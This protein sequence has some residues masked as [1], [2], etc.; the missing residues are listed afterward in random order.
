M[1][2]TFY[3][4]FHVQGAASV[5]ASFQHPTEET[6]QDQA[7]VILLTFFCRYV[8]LFVSDCFM[9][10]ILFTLRGDGCRDL[11]WWLWFSGKNLEYLYVYLTFH[12]TIL[13]TADYELR[14]LLLGACLFLC[15][16]HQVLASS[17][18]KILSWLRKWRS[19]ISQ[20]DQSWL[21][22][23]SS[24]YPRSRKNVNFVQ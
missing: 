2:Y 8:W 16:L 9:F 6:I 11:N 18:N 22:V 24:Y 1:V 17:T 12:C 10:I 21:L 19:L 23:D 5:A 15:S 4:S 7:L 20:R 3:S 13:R 14:Y